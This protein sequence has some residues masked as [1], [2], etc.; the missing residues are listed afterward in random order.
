LVVDHSEGFGAELEDDRFGAGGRHR[1]RV[2]AGGSKVR[3]RVAGD[4]A[5][6][7]AEDTIK[8]ILIK[9]PRSNDILKSKK[10]FVSHTL[11]RTVAIST[12][13]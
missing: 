5:L 6:V 9:E 11:L 1:N 3:S 12:D 13:K 10:H 2:A 4:G 7:P 8:N